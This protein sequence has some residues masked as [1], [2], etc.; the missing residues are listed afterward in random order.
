MRNGDG[1]QSA[2]L[3]ENMGD[4]GINDQRN[5]IPQDI[6]LACEL[7]NRLRADADGGSH[8]PPEANEVCNLKL[9]QCCP[10]LSAGRDAVALILTHQAPGRWSFSWRRPRPEDRA[11][12]QA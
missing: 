2:E 6:R 1:E 8:I 7:P 4:C 10:R 11:G 5:A 12:M 9:F 3:I